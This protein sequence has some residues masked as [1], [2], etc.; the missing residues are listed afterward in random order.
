[1]MYVTNRRNSFNRQVKRA[2]PFHKF[3]VVPWTRFQSFVAKTVIFFYFLLK[4]EF[5]HAKR[6][7]LA[8]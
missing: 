4:I 3:V 6:T 1:M 5:K 7:Q 8:T 2:Q